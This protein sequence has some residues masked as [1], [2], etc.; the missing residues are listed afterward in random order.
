MQE[1]DSIILAISK[2]IQNKIYE[3]IAKQNNINFIYGHETNV[4]SRLIKSCEYEKGTD[5]FRITTESPFF[6]FDKIPVMWDL[7]KENNFDLTTIDDVP[8]GSGFE[9]I[10][11]NAYK[12]S[13]KK[14]TEKHRSEFCS[15]F[16]RENKKK[17]RF[18][19]LNI[20]K[21]YKR[22]ELRLTADYPE[23]LIV[24]RE[25]YSH[26]K[27]KYPRIKVKDIIKFLDKNKN[28]K[29]LI[30]KYTKES[31]KLMNV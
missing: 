12:M 2:N 30:S 26:L 24:L 31:K 4:L 3:K 29:E 22:K 16:I 6:L 9:I 18:H 15:L 28:L 19:K 11:L 13:L 20:E 17:F 5:L 10:K 23:D 21:I 25:I 27:K 8:D 1:I 7:H 14:G